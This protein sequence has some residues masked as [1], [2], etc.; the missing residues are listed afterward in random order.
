[1]VLNFFFFL[2]AFRVHGVQAGGQAEHLLGRPLPIRKLLNDSGI[3]MKVESGPVPW[4][5]VGSF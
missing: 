3:A 4:G 5:S 1:M 2:S